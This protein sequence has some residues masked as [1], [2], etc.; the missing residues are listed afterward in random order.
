MTADKN[1]DQDGTPTGASSV[2]DE[3]V[4]LA[5]AFAGWASNAH[6]GAEHAAA[7]SPDDDPT[8][9]QEQG[10]DCGCGHGTTAEAVCRNCPVCRA[11]GLV[12]AMQPELLDRVADL[13]GVVAGGLHSAA[14][15]RRAADEPPADG[16]ADAPPADDAATDDE[17][18]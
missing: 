5:Q 6:L 2:A 17:E 9:P 3:A 13:I 18:D 12:Q 16:R 8:E 10:P 4:R 15:Q 1:S 11:A 7:R 14:E